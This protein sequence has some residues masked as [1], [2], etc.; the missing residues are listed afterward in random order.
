MTLREAIDFLQYEDWYDKVQK[1]LTPKE[2]ENLGSAIGE[3][4]TALDKIIDL[5]EEK[6]THIEG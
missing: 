6:K 4:C 1:V 5:L 3:V 2:V